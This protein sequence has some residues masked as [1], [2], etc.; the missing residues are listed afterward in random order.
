MTTRRH[1]IASVTAALGGSAF[2]ASGKPKTVLLQSAWDTINIGDIGHTPGTLRILEEHLP[3]VRVVL[4]ASKLDE[5]VEALLRKR[6]PKVEIVQGGLAGKSKKDAALREAIA[7]CDLFIR[8]SGMGQGTDYME[9]CRDAAKPYGLYGQSFFPNMVEGKGAEERIKLL[10]NA[11]FIYCRETKTL[12]ILKNAGV[13]TPVLEFGPDGCFGIDVRDEERGLATMKK[14]GLEDRQFITLQ[15]RTHTAKHPGVDNPPLNPLNPT[16]QMVADDERRAAKYR[17]LVTMWVQKTGKKVL[18]AP[19][20]KKEMVHNK[21]L[22]YDLLPPEIQKNVLNLETFWNAD[23]AASVFARAHT[24]VCHEP[25]SPIIAL[26]NGTPI[27]HTY[28][29]FHSPKCWMFKDI[30]LG[31]WLLEFDETP[32]EKMAET[33]LAIDSDYPAALAKVKKAMDFVHERQGAT[34]KVVGEI[35]GAA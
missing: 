7:G 9:Y 4:W 23:E 18:I 10:N 33:L 1:F 29:E 31:E 3:E 24:I 8:N 5:R 32:V 11:A 28:S 20:V 12:D 26:A 25:H 27:I 15:L 22:I 35:T 30:G 6:F 16:P 17:E 21:R 34:M 13:K 2:A 14:L 19:E